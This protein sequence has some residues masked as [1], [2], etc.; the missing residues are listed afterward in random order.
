MD[1]A[2]AAVDSSFKSNPVVQIVAVSSCSSAFFPERA[3]TMELPI[4]DCG[5]G[6]DVSCANVLFGVSFT[7]TR[8]GALKDV[9]Q[10]VRK[11]SARCGRQLT[12]IFGSDVEPKSL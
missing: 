9:P 2:G 7:S 8:R 6:Y 5:S 3:S 10:V 4:G 12:P 11:C 1:S